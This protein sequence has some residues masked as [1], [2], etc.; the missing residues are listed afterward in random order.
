MSNYK[1]ISTIDQWKEVLEKSKDK[2]ALLF[3]HSTTCPIS[4]NAYREF[5]DFESPVETYLVK[6][7]ESRDVSNE[8]ASD[9]NVQHAS[10]QALL[11]TNSQVVWNA[12]HGRITGNSLAEAVTEF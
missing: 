5:V 10:P 4:A 11:I 3:K 9:V 12:S 2:P 7:I 6:V 8:I 1:E